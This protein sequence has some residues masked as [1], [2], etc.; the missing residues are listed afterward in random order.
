VRVLVYGAGAVGSLLGAG[1]ARSGWEVTLL[2]RAPHVDAVRAAGLRVDGGCVEVRATA[3]ARDLDGPFDVVVL[4]VKGYDTERAAPEVAALLGPEG[5][6]VCVQNGVGHEEVVAR[7]VGGG[8]VVAGAVTASVS[9]AGPGQVV[10]HTRGGVALAAWEGAPLDDLLEA[11]RRGGL[12]ARSTSHARSLKW[13]KLLLNLVANATGAVLDL[14]PEEVYRHRGLFRLE[15][16]MLREAVAVGEALG[17][18]WT[19]LPGYPVRLLVRLLRWPEPVARVLL[20]RAASAGRGGKMP[21]L[22]HDV[23]RGRTEVAFLN[24]AVARWGREV[25]VPAAV[26]EALARLVEDLSAG[27]RDR[28]AFRAAPQA[29]LG[30][31]PASR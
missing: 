21:S 17:V 29:L 16:R 24:G 11:L 28:S 31:L 13:S 1:L 5:R 3:R 14:P 20:R 2:G 12:P 19:D 10:R 4:A 27:R 6:V 8:R 7:Y 26:N 22:W 25:G 30:E 18:R 9:L 15:R 23:R